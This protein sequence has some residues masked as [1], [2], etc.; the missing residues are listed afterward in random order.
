MR[1][2]TC[3]AEI[4]PGVGRGLRS[5]DMVHLPR[6]DPVA[7]RAGVDQFT[8][9]RFGAGRRAEKP[10]AVVFAAGA[11]YPG[12]ARVVRQR[13]DHPDTELGGDLLGA[14]RAVTDD[15]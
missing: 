8:D 6:L 12:G 1:A 10:S 5:V 11:E 15:Q 7:G 4:T 13:C 14:V 9:G 2:C 3:P